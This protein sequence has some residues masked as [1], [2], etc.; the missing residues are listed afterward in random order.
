MQVQDIQIK[1]HAIAIKYTTDNAQDI[2][3]YIKNVRHDAAVI[4]GDRYHF[5]LSTDVE[6]FLID[7]HYAV[8]VHYASVIIDW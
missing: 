2:V 4:R 3:D 8:M 7:P 6:E 1:T 5:N